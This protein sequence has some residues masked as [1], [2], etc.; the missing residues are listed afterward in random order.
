MPDW[1]PQQDADRFW[2]FVTLAT[3]DSCW[4]WT[5]ARTGGR[6]GVTYGT[7]ARS[8]RSPGRRMIYA[9]RMAYCLANNVDPATL[10]RATQVRHNC[11]NPPCCNPRHLLPGTPRDNARDKVARGRALRGEQIFGAILTEQAV[12]EIKGLLGR[13]K[14]HAAIAEIYGVTR[15]AISQIARGACWAWVDA[16]SLAV[17][18]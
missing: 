16:P 4:I 1:S 7:F 5:G 18:V 10:S 3:P 13:G 2:R 9:H 14:R 6:D 8:R 12:R 15:P 11:D 17:A